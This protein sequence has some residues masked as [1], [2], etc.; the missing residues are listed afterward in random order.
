[1]VKGLRALRTR[2]LSTGG[3]RFANPPY[4]CALLLASALAHAAPTPASI[5]A[6]GL[7][8][9]APNPEAR[10]DAKQ[11]VLAFLAEHLK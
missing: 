4:V 11:R 10:E 8:S 6:D 7:S 5:P 3:L 2:L 9:S 1:M